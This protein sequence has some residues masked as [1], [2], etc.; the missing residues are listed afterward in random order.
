M[1]M[2]ERKR[3]EGGLL[4]RVMVWVNMHIGLACVCL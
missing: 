2:S 1:S 4:E 3:R